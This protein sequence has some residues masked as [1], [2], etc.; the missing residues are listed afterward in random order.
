MQYPTRVTVLRDTREKKTHGL[1][2]PDTLLWHPVRGGRPRRL[3]VRTKDAELET[4][5][6]ALEGHE[7]VCLVEKKG[8]LGELT[9]NLLS[10]DYQRAIAAFERL[11]TA[12]RC[13]YLLICAGAGDLHR[14]TKYAPNPAA[15]LDA[16][17]VVVARYGLRLLHVG[18]TRMPGPRRRAGEIV[19]RLMLAHAFLDEWEA[20]E[21]D[22]RTTIDN[23]F[24]GGDDHDG[25][26]G[27]EAPICDA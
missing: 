8:S 4:G 3:I 11:S 27:D 9:K 5:D 24:S 1:L 14:P 22:I 19:L 6:Y 15:T 21:D 26:G 17:A 13:P 20:A 12:C 2:F 18:Q 23:I 10:R 7:H 25:Q 16:L